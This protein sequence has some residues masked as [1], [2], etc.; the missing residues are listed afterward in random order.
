[1]GMT[2]LVITAVITVHDDEYVTEYEE[3]RFLGGYAVF[4]KYCSPQRHAPEANETDIA[5]GTLRITKS[6][7]DH[8][9]ISQYTDSFDVTIV[10]DSE[11]PVYR[12]GHEFRARNPSG[13]SEYEAVIHIVLPV[14][15][16]LDLTSVAPP[17]Q[18]GW[19]CGERF[20]VGWLS[21]FMQLDDN[22]PNPIIGR[23]SFTFTEIA[24][25][26]FTHEAKQLAHAIREV[27]Q[28][29]QVGALTVVPQPVK[30]SRM[31]YRHLHA[32]LVSGY[33]LNSLERMMSAELGERMDLIA[34]TSGNFRD[35]VDDVIRW[36]VSHSQVSDLIEGA[37]NSNPTNEAIQALRR[38]YAAHPHA[39]FSQ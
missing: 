35:V 36:A 6:P 32:A 1:M 10:P 2:P 29:R 14:N 12:Y 26:A 13:R 16:L 15:C 33:N 31:G 20:V 4:C 34:T 38:D 28:E 39:F 19:C 5:D 22:D 27:K 25:Q 23:R 11:P 9:Y 30:L 37:Y 21:G 18:Y 7:D 8:V 3:R 24:Q 17:P